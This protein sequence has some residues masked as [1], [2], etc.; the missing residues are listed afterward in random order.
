MISKYERHPT[1][2]QQ[3]GKRQRPPRTCA[4]S[5]LFTCRTGQSSLLGGSRA[6]GGLE[7]CCRTEHIAQFGPHEEATAVSA[8]P[9][10]L[11]KSL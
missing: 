5:L 1:K 8:G 11:E 10:A 6:D 2:L 4:A 3:M 9:R 7:L